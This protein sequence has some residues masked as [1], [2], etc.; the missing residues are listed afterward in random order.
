MLHVWKELPVEHSGDS[1]ES[2]TLCQDPRPVVPRPAG[3]WPSAIPPVMPLVLVIEDDSRMRKHLRA[4]LA[5]QRFRVIEAENGSQGLTRACG[6]DPD[7]VILDFGLPDFDGIQVT[8]KLRERTAAPILMLSERDVETDKVAALDAGANYYLTKP[9][10]TSELLARIRVW[11]RHTQRGCVDSLHSTIE[12]GELRI[13]FGRRL[14][15]VG[16]CQ[17]RLTPTQYKLFAT[18]MRSAGKV[19]T[20]EQILFSVWGP[21]HV[22][23]TQYLRVCIGQLRQKLEGDPT[24]PRYLVTEPG[25]GYRLRA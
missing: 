25:V 4:T 18:M 2:Q 3:G 9:F 1:T 15:F 16:D 14:V 6:H 21:A 17:V 8:T 13:D 20:H 24:R 22:E 23:D 7:L 11:L 10:G 12:V 5:D 19:L